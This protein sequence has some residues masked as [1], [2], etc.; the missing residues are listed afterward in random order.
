MIIAEDIDQEILTTLVINKIRGS[1]GVAAIKAPGFGDRRKER[2]EDMAALTG[3]TVV[4]EEKGFLL[5]NTMLTDL[6]RAKKII[7]TKENTTIINSQGE[8][9][10]ITI[11]INQIKAQ[12]KHATSDYDKEKLRERLAQLSGG[13]A[14]LSIGAATEL[15]MKEKKDRVDD[16]LSATKAAV[17]EGIV[18]GGGVAF[19]RSISAVKN[20]T[21]ANEDQNTGI[22]IIKRTLEEPL[23]QIVQNAGKEGSVIIEEVKKS[24]SDYG[25]NAQ[26]GRFEKLFQSGVI[27]PTKITRI[28]LENAASLAGF[29]LTTECLVFEKLPHKKMH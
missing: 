10:N 19:I 7:I 29:L 4:S 8:K 2:L 11:R 17:E 23:R 21:G 9:K 20:L 15:E 22:D 3:G 26:T 6:G 27:D 28:A 13:V 16:A 12:I 5:E 14:I 1:L 24:K 18:P 25:F